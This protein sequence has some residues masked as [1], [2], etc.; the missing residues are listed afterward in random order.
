M[1]FLLD[2]RKEILTGYI[3]SSQILSNFLN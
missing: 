2:L 1:R 3:I